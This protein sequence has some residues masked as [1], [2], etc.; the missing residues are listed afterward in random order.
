M[1][2]SIKTLLTAVAITMIA[3]SV[4]AN[5]TRT[6]KACVENGACKTLKV[7]VETE[8]FTGKSYKSVVISNS[9]FPGYKN[10]Q[11]PLSMGVKAGKEEAV[12]KA[13][14]KKDGHLHLKQNSKSEIYMVYP[15]RGN[16]GT[17]L[18]LNGHN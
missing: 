18:L 5:E 9:M 1:K 4:M 17:V 13:E 14:M 16:I 11:M 12:I 3:T 10:E 2:T 15:S 7:P 6:V 8:Q